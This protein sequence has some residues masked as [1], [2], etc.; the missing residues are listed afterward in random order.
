MNAPA[1][2]DLKTGKPS[3]TLTALV[4]GFAVINIKLLFSGIQF[5]DTIKFSLFSGVD[6]G[7]AMAG[8]GGIYTWRKNNSIK[9]DKKVEN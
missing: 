4:F 5:T 9:P 8:L 6:Y 2:N 1:L 3:Y 7:A